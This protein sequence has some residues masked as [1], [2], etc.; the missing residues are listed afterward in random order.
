MW[1][2]AALTVLD[3]EITAIAMAAKSGD[4]GMAWYLAHL[5]IATRTWSARWDDKEFDYI[6]I[7]R[8]ELA[9][10]RPPLYM[11]GYDGSI[12]N[13]SSTRTLYVN[14]SECSDLKELISE[15]TYLSL[16]KVREAIARLGGNTR[17]DAER[18]QCSFDLL[19]A[20]Q[21]YLD[22]REIKLTSSAP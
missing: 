11:S 7:D 19:K 3:R 15:T 5:F 6:G 10:D 17:N 12:W 1:S 2:K 16:M 18:Q 9:G 14:L 4:Y 8:P 20:A 21:S 22:L 13:T